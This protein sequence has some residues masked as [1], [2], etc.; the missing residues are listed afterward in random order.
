MA[1]KAQISEE[2]PDEIK[3]IKEA[4]D[5][6]YNSSE[7]D[8]RRQKMVAH[9]AL[10]KAELWE[11][12]MD[13]SYSKAQVN[14]V[15]SNIEQ[16]APLLTDNRPVWF[17]QSRSPRYQKL[18]AL[19]NKA[20]EYLWDYR[21]LDNFIFDAVK[22]D[23][24]F[25]K[26]IA[27]IFWNDEDK[28]VDF[29]LIDPSTFCLAPGYTDLWKAAWCGEKSKK[30]M[31]W[32]RTVFPDTWMNVKPEGWDPKDKKNLTESYSIDLENM[33][34]WVYQIWLRDDEMI[35]EVITTEE[36]I[37]KGE[38]EQKRR[39]AKYPHGRL[40]TFTPNCVLRD[41]E[42]PFEHGKPPYVDL[43]NYK[44]NH[45]FWSMG[46]VEQIR[47]L[48]KEIN[49]QIQAIVRQG[50]VG[51]NPNFGY[52][53]DAIDVDSEQLK[54]QFFEGGNMW[55]IKPRPDGTPPIT[56]IETGGIDRRHMEVVAALID[57]LRTVSGQTELSEGRSPKK[58][59]LSAS[60]Y[61]GLLESS[62][63]RV[64]QKVRNLEFFIKRLNWLSVALQQ[65]YY[66][67]PRYI[68]FVDESE[69]GRVGSWEVISNRASTA[70]NFYRPQREPEEPE[71]E[72]QKR[73]DSDEDYQFLLAEYPEGKEF[74]PIYFPFQV[75]VQSS[76]TLPK[77][78]QS[79]SRLYLQLAGIQVTENSIVDA[80]AVLEAL[81]IP[82]RQSI[83]ARKNAEKQQILQMKMQQGQ[84][85]P[86]Q[87]QAPR[88]LPMQGAMQ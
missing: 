83:I 20:L 69:E 58:E 55:P 7:Y 6:V 35:E 63:V 26:A 53:P 67:D 44:I 60:E 73:F 45:E 71:E 23:L 72:Y 84:F 19:Y 64:R 34:A 18:A 40:L 86:P 54:A 30:P 33:S 36:A 70:Q 77:D 2:L 8:K 79:L 47:E 9:K 57:L 12:D 3:K 28:E 48:H 76:S 5:R 68:C 39:R 75:Q 49:R 38:K 31:T 25:G 16:S 78:K 15:F 42:S 24:L 74:D 66:T 88:L 43:S 85:R 29:D 59:R 22:D 17:L 14:F 21:E 82:D 81:Q 80:M 10:Y 52:D 61:A 46:E 62:Y 13:A 37:E 11:P 51:E 32:I 1:K 4:F 41:I 65:Q 56:K 87:P 27:N 50:R